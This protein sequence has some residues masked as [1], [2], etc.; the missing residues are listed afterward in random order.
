MR[1]GIGSDR[2]YPRNGLSPYVQTYRVRLFFLSLGQHSKL[3]GGHPTQ[4]A[5]GEVVFSFIHLIL[6][7]PVSN[8]NNICRLSGRSTRFPFLRH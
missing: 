2:A 3:A 1:I 4:K 5:K 7:S 6:G 8:M